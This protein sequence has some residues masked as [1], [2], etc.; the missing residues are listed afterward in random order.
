VRLF[1]R[2]GGPSRGHCRAATFRNGRQCDAPI[3]EVGFG[4]CRA[5]YWWPPTAAADATST[6]A[7]LAT[8]PASFLV[9]MASA[10]ITEWMCLLPGPPLGVYDSHVRP[11]T[12]QWEHLGATKCC[13]CNRTASLTG[14]EGLG[15][16]FGR[17]QL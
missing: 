12:T 17:D 3:E 5:S 9:Q 10:K 13:T 8:S 11:H 15:L 6:S 4:G 16:P 7:A 1:L 2:P 14:E